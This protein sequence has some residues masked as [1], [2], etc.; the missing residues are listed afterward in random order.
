[1][2]ASQCDFVIV[3]YSGV[4]GEV[5]QATISPSGDFADDAFANALLKHDLAAGTVQAHEFGSDA[6][7]GEAVFAPAAP[8]RRRGRRLCHGLRAKT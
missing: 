8:R 2:S 7:A 4:I 3:G 5:S 1:M 6:T